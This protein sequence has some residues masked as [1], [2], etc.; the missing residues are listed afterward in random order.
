MPLSIVQIN[1][2]GAVGTPATGVTMPAGG[3]G[4]F[5][6]LSAI[7]NSLAGTLTVKQYEDAV[8]QGLISG[9]RPILASGYWNSSGTALTEIVDAVSPS[10]G[11]T[12]PAAASQMSLVSSS[13]NDTGTGT[14]AQ[15]VQITYLDGSMNGPYTETVTLNGTTPVNTVATDLRFIERLVVTAA[16]SNGSN[17]GTIT[18]YSGP[19]GTGTAINSFEAT[20]NQTHMAK[21]Y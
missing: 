14:G 10:S 15:K 20:D 16:G 13:A 7:V 5:G 12:E 11:Y 3:S 1:P 4:F 8:A 21:H 2:G 9:A 19:N 18:L 6:W 17:A